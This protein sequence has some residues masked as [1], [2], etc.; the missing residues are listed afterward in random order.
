MHVPIGDRPRCE[1]PTSLALRRLQSRA[2]FP[3]EPAGSNWDPRASTDRRSKWRAGGVHAPSRSDA[4]ADVLVAARQQRNGPNPR[5]AWPTPPRERTA[6]PA[7]APS[8]SGRG[9]AG[10]TSLPA[11]PESRCRYRCKCPRLQRAG[12]A[13]S[14]A[15]SAPAL[16]RMPQHRR[17]P[18]R[19]PPAAPPAHAIARRSSC[20]DY[21][22]AK[23]RSQLS[24][25]P[26]D[27]TRFHS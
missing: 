12:R 23:W 1:S 5:F 7:K 8:R 11:D 6:K 26:M 15:E 19:R 20:G 16:H 18:P 24:N 13:H 25:T 14:P 4:P 21:T 27:H 9:S 10:P 22:R 2:R 17:P 3:E